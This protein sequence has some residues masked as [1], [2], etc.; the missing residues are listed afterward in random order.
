MAARLGSCPR[1]VMPARLPRTSENPI[2]YPDRLGRR[3]RIDHEPLL[4]ACREPHADLQVHRAIVTTN[5]HRQRLAFGT[6]VALA[7]LLAERLVAHRDVA[8]LQQIIPFPDSRRVGRASST[9]LRDANASR[10]RH[11]RDAEPRL[12]NRVYLEA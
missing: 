4:D 9:Y 10:I 6:C 5:A 11:A 12:T 7:K 3:R 8:H 1:I 2:P